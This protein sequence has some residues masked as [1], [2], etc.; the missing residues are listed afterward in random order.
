MAATLQCQLQRWRNEK[1]KRLL[2]IHNITRFGGVLS[3]ISILLT[4]VGISQDGVRRES[5]N[6]RGR[7][8]GCIREAGCLQGGTKVSEGSYYI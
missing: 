5:V 1:M 6:F 4:T 8:R 2:C 7:L 3:T